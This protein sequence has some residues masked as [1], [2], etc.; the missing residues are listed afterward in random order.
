MISHHLYSSLR[1]HQILRVCF[2]NLIYTHETSIYQSLIDNFSLSRQ[3]NNRE[4]YCI[5]FYF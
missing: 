1:H 3:I 5:T 2:N 4:K